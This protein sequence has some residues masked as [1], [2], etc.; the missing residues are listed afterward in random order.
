MLAFE[1][2]LPCHQSGGRERH[3]AVEYSSTTTRANA[4]DDD[5]EAVPPLTTSLPPCPSIS[6]VEKRCVAPPPART[7][8]K[9]STTAR[10]CATNHDEHTATRAYH[11]RMGLWVWWGC[12]FDPLP[13]FAGCVRVGVCGGA[14]VLPPS[15]AFSR[16]TISSWF[17][18]LLGGFWAFSKVLHPPACSR[19][20][21]NVSGR[22]VSCNLWVARP[23][24]GGAPSGR[25]LWVARWGALGW[26]RG[27][28]ARGG[29]ALAGASWDQAAAA[30][31]AELAVARRRQAIPFRHTTALRMRR[32]R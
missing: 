10:W 17:L 9:A 29:Q 5:R 30:G 13:P 22:A 8:D 2:S 28:P 7:R 1:G 3:P 15:F 21:S 27:A 18:A 16:V 31:G 11:S 23:G 19:S 24:F 14:C 20:G 12:G 26:S 25:N 32:P 6:G 4:L